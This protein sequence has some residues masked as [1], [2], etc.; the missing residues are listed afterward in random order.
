MKA[1]YETKHVTYRDGRNEM[2]IF[3]RKGEIMR[4]RYF[5]CLA[6][7]CNKKV[8]DSS[9]GMPVPLYC[10]ARAKKLG[11]TPEGNIMPDLLDG[12]EVEDSPYV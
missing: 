5:T 4:I 8:A 7:G 6:K 3:A 2:R 12:L 11:V 10:K 9:G 1:N